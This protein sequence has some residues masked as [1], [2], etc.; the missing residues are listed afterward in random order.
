MGKL[1]DGVAG[2]AEDL[3]NALFLTDSRLIYMMFLIFE[4]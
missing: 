4:L 2:L 3:L 1:D